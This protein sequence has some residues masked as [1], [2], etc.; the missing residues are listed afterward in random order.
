MRAALL[1]AAAAIACASAPASAA[2][3]GPGVWH[4]PNGA[5]LT[6]TRLDA[7]TGALE[8]TF[9]TDVVQGGCQ[10]GGR[11][12][13]VVGWYDAESGAITFSA[14]V[15]QRGCHAVIAWSGHYD[16]ESGKLLTQFV[17]TAEG[18]ASLT[19]V[20]TFAK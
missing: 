14:H 11:P 1:L 3:L 19:G 10:A 15:P 5:A 13:R 7:D 20:A 12:Q 8:G 6:L 17:R 16:E 2:P 9:V 18:G 4:S